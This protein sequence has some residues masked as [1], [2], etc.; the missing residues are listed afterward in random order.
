MLFYQ[1][2]GLVDGKPLDITN[3]VF[4]WSRSIV[5]VSFHSIHFPVPA[6]ALY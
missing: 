5:E 1:S 6:K 4:E 3:Q 2:N